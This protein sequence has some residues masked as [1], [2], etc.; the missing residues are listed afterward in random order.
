MKHRAITFA[1]AACLISSLV[2]AD[3]PSDAPLMPNDGTDPVAQQEIP[4]DHGRQ[5]AD[6]QKDKKDKSRSAK[7]KREASS[8]TK[9]AAEPNSPEYPVTGNN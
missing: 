1:F 2:F 6:K 3:N 7:A 5:P 4:A 8:K 9:A